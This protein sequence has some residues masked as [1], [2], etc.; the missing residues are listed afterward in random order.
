MIKYTVL[1]VA[2]VFTSVS[3]RANTTSP[4]ILNS[5]S[6]YQFSLLS[7][8]ETSETRG[9]SIGVFGAVDICALLGIP[10][11][12]LSQDF[13]LDVFSTSV[14]LPFGLGTVYLQQ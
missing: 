4:D 12:N 6:S 10:F 2:L 13:D 11:C 1:L 8:Q 14:P 7:S 3:A 5:V 9:E